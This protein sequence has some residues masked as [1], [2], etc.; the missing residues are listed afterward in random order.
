MCAA[1]VPPPAHL[2]NGPDKRS[3]AAT[4]K[5]LCHEHREHRK[6]HSHAR[7]TVLD[8]MSCTHPMPLNWPLHSGKAA[9]PG[10]DPSGALVFRPFIA[11]PYRNCWPV[12]QHPPPTLTVWL[13]AVSR[14]VAHH[15][16]SHVLDLDIS[17]HLERRTGQLSRILERGTR[18]TQMIFRAVVF[19]LFPTSLELVL[20]CATLG[21]LFNGYV[22]VCVG[23]TFAVYVAWT[24]RYIERSARVRK[25]VNTLDAQTTGKVVDALLNYETVR[26]Q[27]SQKMQL[28]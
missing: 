6:Q 2:L 20:V 22:V 24:M 3:T 4:A 11:E 27:L 12:A 15:T 21:H 18:S 8:H 7:S 23:V 9:H 13:Q 26:H 10:S 1:S 16:F 28:C 14:R 17:F 25:D 19:T 5:T